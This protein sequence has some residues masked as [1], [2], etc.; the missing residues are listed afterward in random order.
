MSSDKAL[1]PYSI[2][3]S[4]IL[5]AKGVSKSYDGRQILN[6]VKFTIHDV[7]RPG[8]REGQLLSILGPSGAGK[9]TLLRILC[10][11]EKPDSGSVLVGT[12]QQ[13]VVAG[14]VGVVA[15]HSPLLE[16]RRA[17]GNMLFAASGNPELQDSADEEE[18][19]MQLLK[20]FGIEDQADKFPAKLSGGQRQRL[21][22][23]QQIIAGNDVI[24]LDE[25]FKG[26]DLVAKRKVGDMIIETSNRTEKTTIIV[27]THDIYEAV[28]I[29][30]MIWLMG[31]QD[32]STGD[33]A[34]VASIVAQ[35]NLMDIISWRD[36]RHRLPA[37]L[38][39][40]EHIADRFPALAGLGFKDPE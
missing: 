2:L 1:F 38:D 24:F 36:D 16:H 32:P 20:S 26:L 3:K 40:I 12:D 18:Q 35:I 37:Y 19:A 34:H 33:P 30:D 8:Q 11:L 17:L 5:T 29:S 21:A 15:Q 6:D 4:P 14:R 27:V 28:R 23:A 39:M 9:T 31:L 13:P 7:V 25:P 22:I 10:G